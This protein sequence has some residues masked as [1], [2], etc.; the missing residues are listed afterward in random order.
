[1]NAKVAETLQQQV[2]NRVRKAY[3]AGYFDAC[4]RAG[5]Q[6]RVVA[7]S[8]AGGW[9]QCAK[10]FLRDVRHSGDEA[11]AVGLKSEAVRF[12][13]THQSWQT[14][15]YS[16]FVMHKAAA[17]MAN[18]TYGGV[19]AALASEVRDN[20]SG[21]HVDGHTP[22]VVGTPKR[23]M[24][25]DTGAAT[26]AATS[27]SS[28]NDSTNRDTSANSTESAR[29]PGPTEPSAVVTDKRAGESDEQYGCRMG[30]SHLLFGTTGAS[31]EG[32]NAT[33]TEQKVSKPTTIASATEQQSSDRTAANATSTEGDNQREKQQASTAEPAT[34][35]TTARQEIGAGEAAAASA[36]GGGR[37]AAADGAGA[38]RQPAAATITNRAMAATT[39]DS[40]GPATESM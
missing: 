8:P 31:S 6:A 15:K 28:R 38:T 34:G 20:A 40:L 37:D 12:E 10:S 24:R 33:P 39:T 5:M 23:T 21:C 14:T 7:L 35:A 16:T 9:Y 11:A 2:R 3:S 18:A 19:R 1:M 36:G 26:A 27:G 25:S 30:M 22:S 13:H 32:D 4:A 17:A 29:G